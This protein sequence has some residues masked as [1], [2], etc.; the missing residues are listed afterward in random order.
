MNG[1]QPGGSKILLTVAAGI[2]EELYLVD[3]ISSVPPIRLTQDAADAYE[4][5][6]WSPDGLSILFVKLPAG[7]D[8]EERD[9]YTLRLAD[10]LL[11]KVTHLPGNYSAAVWSPDGTH[12]MYAEHEGR[13]FEGPSHLFIVNADGTGRRQLTAADR[14]DTSPDWTR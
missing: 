7:A 2:S 8:Q 10:G 5:A 9:I 3:T 1:W 13:F 11:L 14:R 4:A 6:S 12:I